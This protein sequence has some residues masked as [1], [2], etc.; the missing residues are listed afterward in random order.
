MNGGGF[1]IPQPSLGMAAAPQQMFLDNQMNHSQVGRATSPSMP[2]FT[3]S[4]SPEDPFGMESMD[5]CSVMT[6]FPLDPSDDLQRQ[7]AYRGARGASSAWSSGC[8][9][10]DPMA[11][12][13]LSII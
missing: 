11:G 5:N 2:Q 4:S 1:Q 3:M 10:Y 12:D 9:R 8:L 13:T 6:P 7:L